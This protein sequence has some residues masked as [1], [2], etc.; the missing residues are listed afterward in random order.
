MGSYAF[1][2]LILSLQEIRLITN[3]YRSEEANVVTH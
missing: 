1:H 3:S 2:F